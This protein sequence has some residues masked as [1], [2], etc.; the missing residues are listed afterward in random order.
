[1]GE[2]PPPIDHSYWET[3]SVVD[4]VAKK[5]AR[6]YSAN[7][8]AFLQDPP[9]FGKAKVEEDKKG[10]SFVRLKRQSACNN[11]AM[12]TS[13]SDCIDTSINPSLLE[14]TSRTSALQL[15]CNDAY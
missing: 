2:T 14:R 12:L 9:C 6:M 3:N 13:T 10:A 4:V 7:S 5:G 1:M 8:L 15:S 11:I